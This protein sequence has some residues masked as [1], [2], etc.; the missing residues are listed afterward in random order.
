MST[1]QTLSALK[2]LCANLTKEVQVLNER[3]RPLADQLKLQ[4][5]RLGTAKRLISLMEET[6]SREGCE[7]EDPSR[8]PTSEDAHS[9]NGDR[10]GDFAPT[11]L[12][13]P[14]IL[15]TLVSLGGRGRSETVTDEVGKLLKTRLKPDD[16]E[17][18]SSGVLRW[19]N[20]VAWQRLN[21]INEGLLRS[22]SPR[23]IWEITEKGRAW[24]K[25]EDKL[26]PS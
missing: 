13:W 16:H 21:M 1:Q 4:E 7:S 2:T 11:R 10:G 17:R 6:N 24:L 23:G 3:I 15:T 26:K 18:L 20:R 9:G 5:E 14:A 25:A 8:P 19:R 12:Y 22:D